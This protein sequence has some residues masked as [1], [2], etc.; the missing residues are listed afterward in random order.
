MSSGIKGLRA[1]GVQKPFL[2]LLR[3]QFKVQFNFA[4]LAENI[5]LGEDKKKYGYLYFGLLAL[6]FVP[7]IVLLFRLGNKLSQALI[8]VNQPGLAVILAVMGAQVFVVFMGL[9]HLMSSLYYSSDLELL[10]AFPLTPRQIMYSKVFV[11]YAGQLL[12]ALITAGPFLITLGIN[13]GGISYWPLALLVFVLI[14]AV[15][16]A[17]GVLLLVPIMKL[18]AGTRKRDLFRVFF[19]LV[20]FVLIMVFQYLNMNMTRYGPETLIARVMEKDGLVSAAAGYYPLLKWA[21][22][23][24]TGEVVGKKLLGVLLYSGASVG[25]FTL[26]ISFSQR[27]FLGGIAM[28]TSASVKQPVSGVSTK[29]GPILAKPRTPFSA[30]MLRGHRVIVRTPNFFL[31]VLMNLLVLPIIML[32][33][34][35]GGGQDLAPLLEMGL[36]VTKDLIVLVMAGIHG[37]F[38]GLNQVAST[39]VS[40]EGQMFWFSKIIPVPPRTQMRAKLAYSL[41]FS[42]VQL[43]ILA[44]VGMLF[45]EFDLSR[46]IILVVLGVLISVPVSSICLLNDLYRPKLNW[47]EPQ[48][49]MKGNFQT[50]VAWLFSMLY[51]GILVVVTRGFYLLGVSYKWIYCILGALIAGSSYLLI[52]WLDQVSET[53]YAQ[54]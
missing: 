45:F 40:R 38:T 19:G 54:L 12:F 47:T 48:Q 22:W 39:A 2:S 50:F 35:I 1:T 34:Y 46:L 33:G 41:L 11:V 53:R 27:W 24:L 44:V 5:G 28:G 16:L 21:A 42:F 32:F 51:L 36:G 29:S 6:A 15:P 31:T 30:I 3:M 14:P 25:L 23:A 49:A 17:L 52:Y 4:K 8:G 18:T 10:Q 26:V 9:S 20:F 43:V 37:M 13:L 7:F